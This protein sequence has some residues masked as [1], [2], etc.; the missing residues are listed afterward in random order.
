MSRDASLQTNAIQ[1]P[2]AWKYILG[3]VLLY[4]FL[5]VLWII[6]DFRVLHPELANIDEETTMDILRWIGVPLLLVAV[7]FGGKWAEETFGAITRK[8]EWQEKTQQLKAQEPVMRTEKARREYVLEVLG[9]GV[10][11][12]KYR[13]GKLWNALQ[14]GSPHTSIR[15]SDP[16]KYSWSGNDKVGDYGSRS[17]DALENGAERTPM[18]WGVPTMYA[19]GPIENPAHLPN[20]IRPMSGLAAGAAGTGMAWHLFVTGPWKLTERPDHLLEQ[21]FA[22]FDAYPDLP[23]LVLLSSDSTA[24]REITTIPGTVAVADGYYIPEQPD[25][26]AVFVL[27]RRER[28]EPLRPY[29]WDD[30]LNDYLQENL[31]MMYYELKDAVPNPRK[32]AH[33]EKKNLGRQPSIAEWLPAAAAF[34]K[35]PVFDN[36][37]R[38]PLRDAFKR[39]ANHPPKDWKPTPWFPVPWNREQMATFDRLPSLGFVHRPVFV[40]FEDEHGKPVVRRDAR[41]K[42]LEAGWQNALQTL[43]DDERAK[44]PARIVAAFDNNVDHLVAMENLLHHYAA[45]GGPE[46]DTGKTAQFINTDRRLGNT[47]AATFFVQTA[48]GVMG[49]YIDGGT[50]AA[51]NLR[52]PAGVSIVFI[53]PPTKERREAQGDNVFKHIVQPSI[54]PD[55]YA[56]PTVGAVMDAGAAQGKS[57]PPARH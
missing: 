28:V 40:K 57:T 24:V 22:L 16:K 18:F 27:A 17:L 8:E 56:T 31:R 12:E 15:E 4:P 9:L 55:N 10:T 47:G 52:D 36:K 20:D 19:G 30:P 45:Q 37:E 13:Q 44:G 33:P 26:T 25:A 7:M 5:F 38:N 35:H 50:S 32:L 23:Y 48:L 3:A 49:S 42:L 14:Q 11:Y 54:D 39:W 6:F 53:S 46:I 41:Q 43:P 1:R 29:V 51:V 2:K 21:A 34:A